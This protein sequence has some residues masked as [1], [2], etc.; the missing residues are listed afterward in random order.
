MGRW[1]QETVFWT[2]I[3]ALGLQTACG[4]S[5]TGPSP[6]EGVTV[7][8]HPNY[9][10]D[11]HMF[12]R[13][14]EN[15]DGL[16]GPCLAADDPEGGG[17]WHHCVSSIRIAEGWEATVFERDDFA[18]QALTITADIADLENEEGPRSCGGN[19]DDC[20]ASIRVSEIN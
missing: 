3:L 13:D 5:A 10:G 1:E 6:T 4:D 7:Y 16:R 12:G 15:L 9:R 2:V 20:I 17:S 8:Q 19:W 14:N 18:G 11:D